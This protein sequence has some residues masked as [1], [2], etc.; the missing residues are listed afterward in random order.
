V[1]T[2]S[3]LPTG[4]GNPN[5][6]RSHFRESVSIH[7]MPFTIGFFAE[8]EIMVFSAFLNSDGSTPADPG[9]S[10]LN[11][12][13]Y[14]FDAQ[15]QATQINTNTTAIAANTASLTNLR[16]GLIVPPPTTGWT[17]SGAF[18]ANNGD[19]L[20][21]APAST[22][23]PTVEY[24]TLP[25]STPYTATAYIEFPLAWTNYV[26][27]GMFLLD[28]SGNELMFGPYYSSGPGLAIGDEFVSGTYSTTLYSRT[29]LTTWPF[30]PNWFQINDNGT[31]RKLQ[32]SP[33]GIDWLTVGSG[34]RTAFLTP[35]RIGWGGYTSVAPAVNFRLHSWNITYP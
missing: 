11:G 19:R 8:R 23:A 1:A 6:R 16:S 26:A 5:R 2:L 32:I 21:T 18:A 29:A 3:L 22:A 35:T 34:S 33:N 7:T 13:F 28:S 12:D 10:R 20:L 27:G 31:N 30:F 4:S 17:T 15:Q 9:G 14:A 24:L 25:A